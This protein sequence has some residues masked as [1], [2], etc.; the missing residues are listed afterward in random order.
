LQT[1]GRGSVSFLLTTIS[2][3][4]GQVGELSNT[5]R[6]MSDLSSSGETTCG[7]SDSTD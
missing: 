2:P 1:Q 3:L 4:T 7:D 5:Q 6:G